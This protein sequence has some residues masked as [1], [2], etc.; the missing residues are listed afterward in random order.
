M[1]HTMAERRA[2]RRVAG[3]AQ[4]RDDRPCAAQG[5]VRDV[6]QLVVADQQDA[7]AGGAGG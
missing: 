4:V 3:I 5:A 1:T 6:G 7:G 2:D